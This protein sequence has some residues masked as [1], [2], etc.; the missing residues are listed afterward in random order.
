MRTTGV[1]Y[2]WRTARKEGKARSRELWG[3]GGSRKLANTKALEEVGQKQ[4]LTQKR[5]RD[6]ME[7]RSR[8]LVRKDR[9][10]N[11]GSTKALKEVC[12]KQRQGRAETRRTLEEEG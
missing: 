3:L 1:I 7:V 6:G 5:G 2:A 10:H 4:R 8:E 12:L 9:S 11:L